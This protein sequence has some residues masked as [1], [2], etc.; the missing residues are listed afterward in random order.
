MTLQFTDDN[1]CGYSKNQ[2]DM[3]NAEYTRWL[4]TTTESDWQASDW[5]QRVADAQ[6]A[7]LYAVDDL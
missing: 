5:G 2:L 7:I 3:A 4:A 1:T 6:A